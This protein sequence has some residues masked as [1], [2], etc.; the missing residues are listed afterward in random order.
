MRFPKHDAA[1]H[2]EHNEHKS[3]YDEI[4]QFIV[5]NRLDDCFESPEAMQRA[6][7]ADSLWVL[8]WYPA[9]PIGFYRIAAPTLEE[10]LAT[11]ERIEQE[12]AK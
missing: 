11:A 12:D 4:G 5:D 2:L 1:L 9:T 6:I 3:C 8:H 7:D 10:L